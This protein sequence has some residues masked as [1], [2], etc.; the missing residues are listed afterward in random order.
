MMTV[1]EVSKLSGVSIRTL[2]YYD[3]IGLLKPSAYTEAG[4]RLYDNASLERLQVILLF[5]E[6]EFP[7]KDIQKI[8]ENP[9]FDKEKA[10]EQQIE[11]LTLKKEHIDALIK[12]A[13]DTK[14]SLHKTGDTMI[15]DFTAFDKKKIDEYTRRAKESWGHTSA[16]KEYEAKSKNKSTEDMVKISN[17]MMKIFT[18]LGAMKHLAPESPEVQSLIKRLQDFITDHYCNCT[19]EILL[20]LGKAYSAGGEMTENIDKAGGTGTGDFA[21]KA[22]Q[23]YCLK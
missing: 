10:L 18:E 1:H 12:L 14:K 7:L 16:Y 5:R 9:D 17:D 13:R 4:Y 8:V 15:M 19:K 21:D 2:Q 23:V 22:I 11:L 3:N 6:L 20:S